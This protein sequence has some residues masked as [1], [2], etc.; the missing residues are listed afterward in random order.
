M[1]SKEGS[2]SLLIILGLFLFSL[3]PFGCGKNKP[4]TTPYLTGPQ[5][6]G[7]DA[8][9]EF[10]ARSTDPN[11]DE[12]R[13]IFDWI[14]K[15]ETTRYYPSGETA[16]KFHSWST[17]GTY[18]IKVRAE[19]KKGKPSDD[20]AK[21]PVSVVSNTKPNPPTIT[22]PSSGLKDSSY[23]FTATSTDPDNDSIRFFF[24]W[25]DG[26]IDTTPWVA[27]GEASSQSH[28]YGDTGTFNIK[29]IAQDKKFAPSDTSA[30]KPFLVRPAFAPGDPL[31]TFQAG[32]EIISSPA[33]VTEGGIPVLYIG[34]KDGRVYKLNGQ[35]GAKI[36]EY[37]SPISGDEFNSSPAISANGTIYLGS[38]EGY[39]FALNPDL[40][41]K[42]KW[43]ALPRG[44]PFTSCALT[45]D[46]KII[47]GNENA[48][49]YALR[50][51]GSDPESLWS[52]QARASIFSS[53]VVDD[54]GYI[55]F[56]DLS[57]SGFVYKLDP[58]G[59][60]IWSMPTNGEVYSSPAIDNQGNIFIASTSG[61]LFA[62]DPNGNPLPNWP[63]AVPETAEVN[64][65]PVFEPDSG[66]IFIGH[67]RG[68]LIYRRN[69]TLKEHILQVVE[70]V[71][72]T[73]TTAQGNLI[74]YLTN[75]GNFVCYNFIERTLLYC[76]YLGSR[77][78]KKLQEEIY[79]SPTL[80]PDG[81]VYIAY[82]DKVYAFYGDKPLAP[83]SWPKFRQGLKNTG[84]LGGGKF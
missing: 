3:S 16:K 5:T 56:A 26:K 4:P 22:G 61:K 29:A 39:L 50:D 71:Y 43:P 68:I 52:F 25:G 38:E 57:D 42:W 65:S 51:A 31:W 79:S 81:R 67:E 69:G 15:T 54:G 59:N 47:V 32:D 82:E 14:D 30:P 24:I 35:T 58:N 33:L 73:P 83:S 49:L 70:D 27:S 34:C 23:T 28:A 78:G 53:P 44:M 84:R 60:L 19:D 6:L 72:S 64:S 63:I 75:E 13:Y 8:E 10:K 55:Y 37:P 18:E 74:Y 40:T 17:P 66:F 76:L 12:I 21:L 45:T 41:L 36:A 48:Y 46:G 1:M 77:S 80:S 62:F 2:L 20:W 7:V 11:N 9:G